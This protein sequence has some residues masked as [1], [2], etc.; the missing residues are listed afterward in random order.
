ME[1]MSSQSITDQSNPSEPVV[2]SLEVWRQQLAWRLLRALVVVG[3]L[4]AAMGVYQAYVEAMFWQI[5]PRLGFYGLLV[6][7]ALW[8]RVSYQVRALVIIGV[9]GAFGAF[10]LTQ[11]GV[12]GESPLFLLS[13]TLAAALFFGRRGGWLALAGAMVIFLG[14]GWAFTSGAIV[15]YYPG[16][17]VPRS[18]DWEGWVL[19]TLVFL[20]LDLGLM[21]AQG[22]LLAR[23]TAALSQSHHLAL[24]LEAE[25]AGLAQQVTERMRNAELAW[26]ETEAARRRLAEEVWLTVGQAQLN[27]RMRGEQELTALADNVLRQLC[28]YLEVPVGAL[29]LREGDAVRLIGR[30]AYKPRPDHPDR[31]RI[32][33]GVVGQAAQD[34]ELRVISDLPADTLPVMSGLGQVLPYYLVLAPFAYEGQLSGVVELAGFAELEALQLEFLRRVLES[35]A[36]AFNT[37][38]NRAQINELVAELQSQ[39]QELRTQ[40]L[41]MIT[42]D[43]AHP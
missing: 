15:V 17:T 7:V 25:R 6:V 37:A 9:F 24:D 39:A 36:V 21:Y 27:D 13:A 29:Y 31:F 18:A 41:A 19:I 42:R 3:G 5:P 2:P 23:L 4:A 8:R 38:Q 20:A 14:V 22:Y 30:Y 40:E 35:L 16:T 32:G 34:G 43:H 1:P 10:N 33:E 26:Q 28:R 11:F 12:H